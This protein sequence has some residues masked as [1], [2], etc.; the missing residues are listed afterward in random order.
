MA[1]GD[2][3]TFGV[4]PNAAAVDAYDRAFMKMRQMER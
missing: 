4:D 1:F 3:I 2:R